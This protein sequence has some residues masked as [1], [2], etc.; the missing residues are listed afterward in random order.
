M[1]TWKRL[2]RTLSSER[3]IAIRNGQD[4]AAVDLHYLGSGQVTGTVVLFSSAGWTQNDV[5]VVLRS[6]DDA[7]LPDVDLDH[8]SLSYT[9]VHG[10]VWGQFEA[11]P[12][13]APG[14]PAPAPQ[15]A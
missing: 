7:M 14:T 2:V 15:P 1:I 8:G 9:V 12:E 5:E 3:F 6:L 10:E 4:V 11:A 13:P